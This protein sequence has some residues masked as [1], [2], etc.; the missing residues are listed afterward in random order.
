MVRI[1]PNIPR[2]RA[3]WTHRCSE[4]PDLLE[5]PMSDGRTVRYYPQI[6]Q[7][8]FARAIE[9]VRNMVV[10][11]EKP[12]DAGTSNRPAK[13]CF[14]DSISQKRRRNNGQRCEDR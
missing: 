11:Y 7:P 8:A 6:E 12:A 10:G 14:Q 5:V 3:R 1:I 4:I 13:D 9:N 2:I